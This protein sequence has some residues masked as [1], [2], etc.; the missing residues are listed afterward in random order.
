MPGQ[1]K[2][3]TLLLPFPDIFSHL[4]VRYGIKLSLAALLSLYV[5]LVLRL[6]HPN[7]AVLTTLVMMNS[8]YVG[9][10]SLKAILRCV[11]TIGG[12]FLGVWLVGSYTSTPIL[13]LP[14]IFI[15]LGIAVYKF[16][17]YPASQAPYAYYLVGLT[18]LSVA[19]YGIQD[20]SD[21]WRTGL[22]R[23]LEILDGSL[24]SLVVT[25]IIWPRYAREEFFELGSKALETTAELVTLETASFIEVR[26]TS[27][28]LEQLH[29][30]FEEQVSTL[31]NLLQAGARESTRF[32][33]R[34]GNYNAFVVSLTN[35]FQAALHLER[36]RQE[37]SQYIAKI[38][39][40]LAAAL[41]A[42]AEEF[43][44]LMR[45]YSPG[46]RLPETTIEKAF[47]TLFEK[48]STLRMA[49][50]FVE[51]SIEINIEFFAHIAALRTIRNELLEMRQIK[52]GLP[53]LRAAPP[54]RK[55]AWDLLPEIDWFWMRT[56][57]KAALAAALS[58]L[59][60]KWVHPP[61]P[62][63]LPVAA[64]LF[65]VLQRTFIRAGGTG[66]LRG[67]Q[68]LFFACLILWVYAALL[69][70]ITPYLAS[71]LVMNLTLFVALFIFGFMTAR[72]PGFSF[73]GMVT[74]LSTSVFVGLNAQVPVAASTIIDSVLGLITGM[75]IATVIGRLIWPLL[76]QRLLRD[77]LVDFFGQLKALSNPKLPMKKIQTRLALLPIEALQAAKGIRLPG[78]T[79]EEQ[80]Q[81]ELLIRALSG[82]AA[83]RTA[84]ARRRCEL[85][86]KLE[87][88]VQLEL[89]RLEIEL[90]QMTDAFADCFRKGDCRREFP[91]VR[92]ALDG[93]RLRADQ[94]RRERILATE[95][96]DAPIQLLEI[97][98][99]CQRIGDTLEECARLMKSLSIHRYWGDYA[100]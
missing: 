38:R 62:A 47:D 86:A 27:G 56:A 36:K 84:L 85:P 58:L 5:A 64:L 70:V 72:T 16:G 44:I 61:G 13:F 76:P 46:A 8:H 90:G 82:L 93:L 81:F 48:L 52:Q 43:Q 21:V 24:S 23:A 33:G 87:A 10:T 45:P 30:R 49:G 74:I 91:T 50:L 51:S 34:L 60:I 77:D 29:K 1:T 79:G 73:W 78:V 55:P 40:E 6:D 20:P 54:E 95:S 2:S 11:G 67:F 71:Y 12:A 28:Q 68:R 75:A 97:I 96:L 65:S 25:S 26:D 15:I 22:N 98:S 99:R 18:T 89:D 3:T 83:R 19:T 59:L 92:G 7:W 80:R 9:S 37:E 100:L 53:R 63:A 4:R 17:Q 57:F 88:L 35:L 69:I 32:Y 39:N 14:I 41:T 66:D 94:I 31:R 42:I